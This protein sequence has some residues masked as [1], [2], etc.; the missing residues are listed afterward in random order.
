[1]AVRS[2]V[3][4]HIRVVDIQAASP[5]VEAHIRVLGS[6]AVQ[7]LVALCEHGQSVLFLPAA[8]GTYCTFQSR[9]L[10]FRA[11]VFRRIGYTERGAYFHTL[12]NYSCKV[13]RKA[14][15]QAVPFPAQNL[16][17]SETTPASAQ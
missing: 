15:E 7:S 10:R 3:E 12:Q 5:P 8:C 2:P 17:R 11:Q 4:A 13:W 14:T 16:G 6:L 9:T 1:M